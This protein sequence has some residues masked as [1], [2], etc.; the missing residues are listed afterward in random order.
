[1][2][3]DSANPIVLGAILIFVGATQLLAAAIQSRVRAI[4]LPV[5]APRRRKA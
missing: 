3:F 4:P 1:M 5:R 2:M